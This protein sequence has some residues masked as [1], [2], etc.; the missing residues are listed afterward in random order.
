M[1]QKPKPL[2][3]E[4]TVPMDDPI[5]KPA[6]NPQRKIKFAMPPTNAGTMLL[7]SQK[8]NDNSAAAAGDDLAQFK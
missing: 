1:P 4:T 8:Y 7:Q 6:Q 5:K 3:K 2:K